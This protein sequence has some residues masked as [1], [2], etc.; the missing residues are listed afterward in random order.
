M[1]AGTAAPGE[2]R[3]G[4]GFAP[5]PPLPAGDYRVVVSAAG[6]QQAVV[7]RIRQRID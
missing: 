3:G 1:R 6:Q 2:G 4:R 5:G 7:G